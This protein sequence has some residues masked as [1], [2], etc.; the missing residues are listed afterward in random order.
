ME[1]VLM[2]IQIMKKKEIL[3]QHPYAITEGTDGRWRT[4]L[5]DP[6]KPN[7]RRQIAK[8]S[9]D[10]IHDA[11]IN[12]YNARMASKEI[13]E[14]TLEKL[15]ENWMLWRKR[16]GTDPKTI[17]ENKN[18]W[19]RFLANH[20]IAKR[21]VCDIE[22]THMEEFFL[23]ITKDHAITA[24]RLGNVKSTLNGIFKHAVRLNIIKHSPLLDMDYSQFRTRCKPANVNYEIYTI[25]ERA[26]I[27]DHLHS[28]H[29][30]YSL[31][32]QLSF[33][34]CLRISELLSIKKENY[35]NGKLYIRNAIRRHQTMND[36]LTF[37]HVEYH[38]EERIKGNQQEGF[39]EI[40]LTPQAQAL[41]KK[42]L[43]LYPEGEYLLMRDGKPLYGDTFNRHL[44][45]VCMTLG[46]VYRSSHQIRF[47]V[48]TL[49]Y[50]AGVPL[51]EI[52]RMLGHSDI[53]TTMHYIRQRKV[54][55]KTSSI[56]TKLLD[57]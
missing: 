51:N 46:I 56:M 34:L 9:L 13:Q 54:S 22:L 10:K 25:E 35:K 48:A 55:E 29:E 20:S 2:K 42:I 28:R 38:I 12:D 14:M 44:K 47:T 45:S 15:Y 7:G 57:V 36:D 39:R 11:V 49:L 24:K 19:V 4:Y 8:S 17:L 21:N 52:S 53:Q 5:T 41:V 40:P 50:E 37:N 32:I 27:L 33:F 30:I 31:A 18:E 1:D 3:E 16:T 6:S 23:D 43:E 26:R